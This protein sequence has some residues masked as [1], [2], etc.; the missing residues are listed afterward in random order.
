MSNFWR[1][2]IVVRVC[3]NIYICIWIKEYRINLHL[4]SDCN[5]YIWCVCV[6]VLYFVIRKT[7]ANS[8]IFSHLKRVL[9]ILNNFIFAI[10]FHRNQTNTHPPHIHIGYSHNGQKKTN[11]L[12]FACALIPQNI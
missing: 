12:D 7:N 2:I 9:I 8:F 4:E 5:E 1:V 6:C 3:I 10:T 11:Y